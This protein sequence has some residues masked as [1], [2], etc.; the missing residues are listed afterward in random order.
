MSLSKGLQEHMALIGGV[1][2][3]ADRVLDKP[4]RGVWRRGTY[5]IAR[6]RFVL[7]ACSLRVCSLI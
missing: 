2:L 3:T 5:R 1:S 4:P 6:V 7:V